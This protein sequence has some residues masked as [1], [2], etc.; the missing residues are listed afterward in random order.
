M[1]Y[2]YILGTEKRK[3]EPTWLYVL[4]FCILNAYYL[5]DYYAM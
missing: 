2:N 4:K 3:G 5:K 1:T